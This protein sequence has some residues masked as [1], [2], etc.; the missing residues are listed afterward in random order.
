MKKVNKILIALLVVFTAACQDAFLD[1]E[2]STAIGEE[3]VFESL[4]TAEAA[5]TGTYDAMSSY[6]FSGLY[7]P[8]MNDLMGEDLMVNSENNW[9]W[10]VPVYQM[11]ILPNYQYNYNVWATGYNIIYNAN[12]II[13]NAEYIP[14]ASTPEI[15][16]LIGQAKAIRSY[17]YF[18]LI[19][20]YA[21]AYNVDPS[22]AGV[23]LR[24][25]PATA[26]DPDLGRSSIQETYDLIVSDLLE[27]I[28]ALTNSND[29]GYFDKRAAQAILARVYL[30][31]G[32]WEGAREMASA[33]KEDLT[34]MP[35]EEYWTGFMLENSETIFKVAYTKDDNNIYLSLPSF[36]WPVQGYS[37]MRADDEFVNTFHPEDVRGF[38]FLL[39]ETI[40]PDNYLILKF[41]H[42]QIIGNAE[43]ISIRG[44]EMYLIEAEAEAELGNDGAAQDILYEIQSRAQAS[45]IKSTNTG[46]DLIDEILLERRKELY[47]EGFRWYDIKRRSLPFKREG[48]HWVKFDFGPN[49]P[50]Y[51]RMTFPIPE[52]EIDA[53]EQLTNADQNPGY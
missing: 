6:S 20:A 21:P 13:T 10:F 31:M 41:N 36:Y 18:Q 25:Q 48:T 23:I 24:T 51:Y 27:A 28:D 37:S 46:Q 29:K 17:V 12:K 26:T 19:Q 50:D 33:A 16:N 47:G 11:D 34:L 44:S 53:N 45:A 7:L 3:K 43:L 2:P 35:F 52:A 9:N 40:D 15:D 22:A 8:V 32:Y 38:N 42:N 39:E 5:L 49:D 14:D 4:Q 30:T 1:T